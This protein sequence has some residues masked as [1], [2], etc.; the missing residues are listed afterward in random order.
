M[1]PRKLYVANLEL[2]AKYGRGDM[3]VVECG[4]WKGGMMAGIKSIGKNVIGFDSFEGLPEPKEIDGPKAM[5]YVQYKTSPHYY[6]NCRA[7][8][9]DTDR[10]LASVGGSL[11]CLFRLW[12][13]REGLRTGIGE[14]PISVLRIDCDW[15]ES[16]KICLDALYGNVVSGGII[17]CDDYGAY[18]GAA[19]AVNEFIA[20]KKI[21]IREYKGVCYFV[22]E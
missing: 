3:I 17:I 22:K 9:R 4:V 5:E 14:S 1:I 6:D 19:R 12:Y 11:Y 16:V 21:R 20:D 8:Y 15:Y 18:D 2:I 13:S 10:F 7:D